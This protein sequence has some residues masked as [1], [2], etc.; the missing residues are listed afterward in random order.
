MDSS[1]PRSK[2]SPSSVHCYIN[3]LWWITT[4][5]IPLCR[6]LPPWLWAWPY[7]FSFSFCFEVI[8]H[9]GT[10]K[11]DIGRGL[12]N[13]CIFG[14]FHFECC[15]FHFKKPGLDSWKVRTHSERAVQLYQPS[16]LRSPGKTR[17]AQ[18]THKVGRKKHIIIFETSKIWDGLPE[19]KRMTEVLI[20][21][22]ISF[23][24]LEI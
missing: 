3:G 19:N 22:P 4:S 23:W 10:R 16:Q 2:L 18:P 15:H 6:L 8:C 13:T 12:I 14:I 1:G 17:T 9:Q 21:I 20:V 5:S 7:G 24:L 11:Y